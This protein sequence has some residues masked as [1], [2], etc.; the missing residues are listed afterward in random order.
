MK[1]SK[2]PSEQQ[3]E[4]LLNDAY[5]V[6]ISDLKQ[7]V[8]LAEQALEISNSLDD[9]NL[10]AQCFS[11]LSLF[12]MIQGHYELCMEYG[13]KAIGL[14]KVTR[15]LQGIADA[16]YSIAGVHYKTDNFHLGL[17][18]LIDCLEIYRN[19][20]DYHNQARVQKSIGT[21][22][23]YFGDEKSAIIAY[24]KSVETAQ[25]VGDTNLESN[26]YNPLSGIYLNR[27]E[28]ETASE[29]IEK[30]IAMK[31]ESND[32]RGLAFALYGRAKV[33][34][35]KGEYDKAEATFL[36]SIK[37][38]EKMG[39]KLGNG[40]SY[41][42]LGA[43]YLEQERLEEAEKTL[44][45]TLDFAGQ[46]NL[47]IIEFKSYYL[48]YEL[49]KR[50]GEFEQALSYLEKYLKAKEGVI[51]MQTQKV[52]E[53]YEALTNMERIQKEAQM[54]REKADI[55][56]KKNLA[57]ESSRI[58]QEFLS[59]MSHEIRTPLNA[60]ITIT[61]LLKEHISMAGRELL[62]S[63]SY[64]SSN[65]LQIINDI[66]DFSKLDA[67]KVELD[68]RPIEL[69]V[70]LST[71][72]NIYSSLA[73][74][75]GI[76]LEL[77]IEDEISECYE[78]DDTK[79]HQILGNLISNAIKFTEKGK[80]TLSVKKISREGDWDQ[81]EFSVSDSGPG[82][83]EDFLGEIF[84]SFSQP[85]SYVTRNGGGSGLG[86][87]IVKKLVQLH[88][89]NIQL[90]TEQGKGSR[91]YFQLSLKKGVF[92]GEYSLYAGNHLKGMK[93]LIA[94]DNLINAMVAEKLLTNHGVLVTKVSNGEE[95]VA[96]ASEKDFDVILMDIHMPK[97]HGFEAAKQ[98]R[99]LEIST[100]IYALTAD[101][102]AYQQDPMRNVFAGFLLKPIEQD[103][104]MEALLG[105]SLK[106][107]SE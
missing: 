92:K 25:I 24:Q 31:Q 48:L 81:I 66:L 15:N 49:S 32:I 50:R 8:M 68:K 105:K 71:I 58:K 55:L 97:M 27:N 76:D 2:S 89:S 17:I 23:E 22:Y 101:I 60:V 44:H 57:E 95:A 104:L 67:G 90:E 38:H 96:K 98:I 34:V 103:K 70:L 100:P 29:L 64:S 30:S 83:S 37:I 86:L 52:I 12:H 74:E 1:S 35:K 107:I 40:M 69:H 20:E 11:K 7:S 6:R 4:Q 87:A 63:L 51:N 19:L 16:K 59:T 93:V 88:G 61:S 26:A 45:K 21:I 54:N 10:I 39:E 36:E 9:S 14:F 65:L 18:Y 80:V 43:L 42:K 5:E 13:E 106:P 73:L 3:V 53:S 102:T 91:F 46:F 56:K 72:R 75:K 94:E 84:Q 62:E 33:Y 82:I 77:N 79:L 99:E 28:I 47:V 85:K 41:Y 78:L